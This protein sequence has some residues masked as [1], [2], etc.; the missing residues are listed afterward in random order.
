M[1]VD[2]TGSPSPRYVDREVVATQ[3][4]LYR[5]KGRNVEGLGPASVFFQVTLPAAPAGTTLVDVQSN[6]PALAPSNLTAE[7]DS[8][9]VNLAW[10]AP[11]EDASSVTGY[12]L[13]RTQ[14]GSTATT[15]DT[16]AASST[17]TAYADTNAARAESHTYR[18]RALRDG[19]AS[20]DS[21]QV[22]VAFPAAPTPTAVD[23]AAVPIVVTSTTSDYFVLY[24]EHELKIDDETTTVE[25]PVAVTLGEEGTTTLSE[26]VK[27]LPK[28][29]Y[30]VEKY[31][32]SSPADVDGDCVDDI[33]ELNNL[34]GMNPVNHA[35]AI[36][37]MDGVVAIPDAATF[38]SYGSIPKRGVGP[39]GNWQVKPLIFNIHTE[40][41]DVYFQNV[42]RHDHHPRFAQFIRGNP[43][44]TPGQFRSIITFDPNLVA[45]NGDL[46]IYHFST[47]GYSYSFSHIERAY[48]LLAASMPLLEDN[49]A[50]WIQTRHLRHHQPEL[51]LF[52]ESRIPVLFDEDI[53]G[54][55]DFLALNPAV[56]YGRL[57]SLDPD[58][59]PHPHDIVLYGALPNELPR[60]AGVISTVPQTPLSH[61]NLRAVQNG[62]PNAF[63]RNADDT[64]EITDLVG[65]YVR[66]EVTDDGWSL[67]AATKAEVDS[68]YES[69][70]PASTQTPER[71]L[72]ATTITPLG[73]IGFDDWDSF[74]VKAANLAV[75]RT[76]EFTDGT[77][78]DGF[79][80]P[81]YFYDEF[82]KANGLYD[83]VTEMLADEDFQSDY[84]EQEDQLK[85]LRKAIKKATS[86]Q[87]I[88]D[89]LTAMHETYP[90]GQ[91][92]RYRSSTNNE[93]LPGFNGAGL[94]DSKTQ[95]AEETDEDGIDKSLKQVFAG[96]WTFRAFT[97]RDF[98]RIDHLSAAMGVLVHPNFSDELANG[99]AVSF[100]SSA[101]RN[102]PSAYDWYYVNTQVGEDL[103]TNPEAH[104]VPEEVLVSRDDDDY[105]IVGTSNLVER[106]ELL[107]SEAQLLQLRDHLKVVHDHFEGLYEPACD[108]Q[109][110]MEV[111]FKITSDNVLSIKQARPWVFG[112]VDAPGKPTISSGEV[113]ADS[114]TLLWDPPADHTVTS[115]QVMRLDREIHALDE[116][117]VYVD[118]TCNRETTFTDT[119]V[120]AGKRYLY[121]V[122][123]RNSGG[124]SEQSNFYHAIIPG[125][126]AVTV[127]FVQAGYTVEEGHSVSVSVTLDVDP[128]RTVDIPVT[129]TSQ[130][131]TSDDDYDGVPEIVTFNSGETEKSF[132][133]SAEEDSDE[134]G[135][136]IRLDFGALP[137][138]VTAGAPAQVTVSIADNDSP[139]ELV[140]NM[141]R[142]FSDRVSTHSGS[143]WAIRFTTGSADHNW[144]LA[145][146]RLQI[147]SWDS[148]VTPT[149]ALH[150]AG[151]GNVPGE[152]IA[153]MTSPRKGNGK[154]IIEAPAGIILEPETTYT[155]VL[156]SDG[157]DADSTIDYRSTKRDADDNGGA[158][159]WSLADDS[160]HFSSGSWSSDSTAIKVAVAGF[161]FE[162][163]AQNTPATGTPTISGTAQVGETLTVDTSG[164]TDADGLDNVSFS[165]QLGEE[166]RYNR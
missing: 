88:I 110:A 120:E 35:P 160:L 31:Q 131:D 161:P 26:N 2:D 53:F 142:D 95:H 34:G 149:V 41:P 124:L 114:V 76:L 109:F 20:D 107:L 97:E 4:Y 102:D 67:R 52:R 25:Y 112:P 125:E 22:E 32:V 19:V 36:D 77:V 101:A 159:G 165:Y 137:D 93:D 134:D 163:T 23:V 94:Y 100:D 64:S 6:S 61:I 5:V 63:I 80:V 106:G 39:K 46:G 141:G 56:G 85:D 29:R 10:D 21:N 73:Q 17:D 113:T 47:G 83:D 119:D 140:G 115:Y 158:D 18:V 79:A 54:D 126:L 92:L 55:T 144:S 75:L 37:A 38:R 143:K 108:Q 117:H 78:P 51:P 40:Q 8:C 121:R 9:G 16:G 58:D 127:S 116:N 84:E 152:L 44:N 57:Q 30:R 33:T 87:W 145:S 59:T 28:E 49:L 150:E 62:I 96:L 103:V 123:A 153:E 151:T 15:L 157:E 136:V 24:A 72:S 43:Y 91:S 156:S 12:N 89:A 70:R 14:A 3:R 154:R 66:Y 135:E 132:E 27:A 122:K 11:T 99:V 118:N 129:A 162:A 50:F 65:S 13:L 148:G 48:A 138:E 45:P 139:V 111:E 69:S 74:G 90:E 164:I 128:E 60:V 86:P 166:R 104:S 1:L 98:H 133:I 147:A 146:L 130:G 42:N 68:H 71:D 81:F 105:S 155:I 7:A 82:M